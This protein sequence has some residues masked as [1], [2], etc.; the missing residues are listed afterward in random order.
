M[1]FRDFLL[2][3]DEPHSDSYLLNII[4]G[5]RVQNKFNWQNITKL[6][7]SKGLETH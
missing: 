2:V 4:E 5:E 3:E 7:I 1:H 6:N